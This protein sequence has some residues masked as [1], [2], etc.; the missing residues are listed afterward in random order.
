[1]FQNLFLNWFVGMIGKRLDG[2]K[3]VIGG[4][5]LI[6]AAL[7]QTVMS[8]FPDLQIPGME[9]VDWDTVLTMGRDGFAALGVGFGATGA[10]HKVFKEGLKQ[11]CPPELCPPVDEV[12]QKPWDGKTPN[13][14]P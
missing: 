7:L 10:A 12:D 4:V 6:V 9:R 3:T 13:Q 1:M 11:P 5:S 2:K 8:M 14:F